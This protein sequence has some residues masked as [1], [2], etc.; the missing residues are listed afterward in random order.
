MLVASV[1]SVAR[2]A[3][4]AALGC[5]ALSA[6]LTVA[7]D[8]Y[9]WRTPWMWPEFQAFWFNVV[10]DRSSEWGVSPPRYYFAHL[11][12]KLL[13]GALPLACI[14]A[15]ADA[16]A[17]CIAAPYIVAIGI[18]SAN[19]HKEWRF[20]FPAVPVFNICAAAGM[21]LLYRVTPRRQ[22][23]TLTGVLLAAG[24]LAATVSMTLISSL[25]YP[26]GHALAK[27]HNMEHASGVRVHIDSFAAMTGVARFGQ[28]RGDWVYDK[29]EGLQ[30][31]QFGNF[32]HLITSTP[33][34]HYER[35]FLVI[36]TQL[37][38]AG[39]RVTTEPRKA[40]Q[41]LLSGQL[42]VAVQ[43]APMVWIMSKNSWRQGNLQ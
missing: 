43:Q 17:S 1:F 30:P 42:P 40:A 18:F 21:T 3:V 35:G 14:G 29:T 16:R 24:S 22:L 7:I 9:F 26:G 33:D 10:E 32:T 41:M 36:G 20:I 23:V 2:R 4:V 31:G 27:L 12:P 13:L 11:L 5:F 38:Y 25:N 34:L 39:L 28:I 15:L 6:L 19:P 37:G 8:S